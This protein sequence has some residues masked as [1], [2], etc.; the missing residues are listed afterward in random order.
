M[1][2][3]TYVKG[4]PTPIVEMNSLGF[5][6]FE[7]FLNEFAP[8]FKKATSKVVD[9][10][11]SSQNFEKI[12]S[13]VNSQ[14]QGEF[15]L[16]KRQVNGII[17]LA[18]AKVDSAVLCRKNHIKQ[19]EGKLKSALLWIKNSEKLRKNSQKFYSKKN[20]QSS[21]SGCKLPLACDLETGRSNWHRLKAQI[22]NK[23][24][25][26]YQLEKK[27]H[28]L[29]SATIKVKLSN[30]EIFIVGSKDE[31]F[32]NQVCQYD[33]SKLTFRVP[34]FLEY[35]FGLNI[36]TTLGSFDRNIN[37]LPSD[38]AK[39][40]HFYRKNSRWVVAVQFTPTTVEKI[41][42]P[43]QYGA[44][45]ID[46][47]PK[48]I[49]WAYVDYQGN[50][51]DSGTIPLLTGLSSNSHEQ[52]LVNACLELAVLASKYAC[53]VVCEELDFTTK[54]QTLREKGR[55]YARMLSG[56]AYSK[57]YR[58]LESIFSNRGITI[59]KRTPAYTSLIGLV[60][61]S[62]MY[63]LSSDIAAALVIARRG[64]NLSERLPASTQAYLDV[65][66]RKHMWS[67]WS[68]LNNVIRQGVDVK[69]RHDYYNVP[70][71][72]VLVKTHVEQV[73]SS[74]TGVSRACVK[75]KR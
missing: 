18:K 70:N 63:G 3:I 75:H 54:K 29:K 4:L 36:E 65:R 74:N 52:Q 22:H 43:I 72:S 57:L 9:I 64:M 27:I 62:R 69:S 32:G 17:A 25:Y 47:N 61:Y 60:K 12:K 31:S 41:S 53:P 6:Q 1:S 2:T 67:S 59:Y 5:T 20:W 21:K 28:H 66:S 33:G 40:W 34:Y 42:R 56:F 39:T 58:L 45:G 10:I 13:K 44:I 24:R 55:K 26:V 73:S 15:N 49:G 30:N 50:L 23:K 46:I 16:N 51:Q 14:I 35:K 48:S 71:W 7:M 37:R 38:G 8:V 19:L 11:L 68:K